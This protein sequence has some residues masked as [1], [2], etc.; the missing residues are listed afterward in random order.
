LYTLRIHRSGIQ[1]Y[2]GDLY[3]L[4]CLDLLIHE[5]DTV[6]SR[7]IGKLAIPGTELHLGPELASIVSTHTKRYFLSDIPSLEY[8]IKELFIN[9]KPV[10]FYDAYCRFSYNI[11]QYSNA[12]LFDAYS[13]VAVSIGEAYK[14]IS[15]TF[16]DDYYQSYFVYNEVFEENE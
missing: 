16:H 9:Q 3:S 15:G 11:P 8:T 12:K 14:L 6:I 5:K 4:I 2:K 13:S 7:E 10:N 1:K